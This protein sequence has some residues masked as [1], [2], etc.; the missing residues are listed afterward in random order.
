M[1]NRVTVFSIYK[2]QFVLLNSARNCLKDTTEDVYWKLYFKIA[3]KKYLMLPLYGKTFNV[4]NS[5][6][7]VRLMIRSTTGFY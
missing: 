5:R 1:K 2:N 3:F 7:D 6:T 4:L